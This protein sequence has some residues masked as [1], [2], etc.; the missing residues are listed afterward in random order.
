M[1]WRA[2]H[3]LE[4]DG[5]DFVARGAADRF[6]SAPDR[7]CLVKRPDLAAKYLDLLAELRPAD[8]RGAGVYQ[9]GAV[10]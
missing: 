8:Y 1:T 2:E 7:F 3:V 4:V 9:G 6:T 5:V 10:P